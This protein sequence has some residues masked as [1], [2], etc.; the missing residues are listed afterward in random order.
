MTNPRYSGLIVDGKIVKHVD[1]PKYNFPPFGSMGQSSDFSSVVYACTQHLLSIGI[2]SILYD[3]EGPIVI[4][5]VETWNFEN[6]EQTKR[7]VV[8][9]E[10]PE[11]VQ[12][13]I[14]EGILKFEFHENGKYLALSHIHA[15]K[16]K[17]LNGTIY[18]LKN[19][20]IVLLH[21][22]D[23]LPEDKS[24]NDVSFLY[25][26]RLQSFEEKK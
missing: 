26:N 9:Q 24:D 3:T 1:Y 21:K 22:R 2:V 5:V 11:W 8:F 18:R 20:T 12:T 10:F 25:Q 15:P 19:G 23:S 17:L 14:S 13:A 4:N 7:D 16:E 6:M